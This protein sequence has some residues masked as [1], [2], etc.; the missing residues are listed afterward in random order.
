M[1][2]HTCFRRRQAGEPGL[3]DGVMAVATIEAETTNVVSMAE[4]HR[5][6]MGEALAGNVRRSHQ[7]ISHSHEQHR[8]G[9]NHRQDESEENICAR[10]KYLRHRK[11][12][13]LD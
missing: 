13:R 1:T 11:R 4:W 10:T 2:G 5:L 9:R 12:F 6:L 7:R 8:R 3:F